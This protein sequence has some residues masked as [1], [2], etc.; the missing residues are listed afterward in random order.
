MIRRQVT[1]FVLVGLTTNAVL[2]VV[3][4]LLTRSL[5]VPKVAM[6]TVYLAGV[7]LGFLANRYWTFEHSGPAR[8][9]LMRFIGAYIVGYVVNL[10][11]LYVGVDLLG[12]RHEFVQAGLI[13]LVAVLMFAMQK[14][15]VFNDWP[16]VQAPTEGRP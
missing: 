14:Y 2:Y 16:T 3:Y 10:V 11:G 9:A 8:S 6:T 4:L 15:F 5:L 1:R 12:W 7:G 13:F